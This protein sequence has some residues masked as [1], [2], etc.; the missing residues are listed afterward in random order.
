MPWTEIKPYVF[1]NAIELFVIY[2][3][4]M[5]FRNAVMEWV[6][7][8]TNLSDGEIEAPEML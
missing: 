7:D 2:V 3:K 6:V 4:Y 8:T 1:D 5:K